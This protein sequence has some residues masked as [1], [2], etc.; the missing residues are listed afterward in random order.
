MIVSRFTLF[1]AFDGT[2]HLVYWKDDPG[3]NRFVWCRP[4]LKSDDY[5]HFAR[6]PIRYPTC[7]AC[8]AKKVDVEWGP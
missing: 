4:D 7:L 3:A 8:V 1:K 6:S 2:V 5:M